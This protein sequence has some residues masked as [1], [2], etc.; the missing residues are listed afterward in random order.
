VTQAT[1]ASGPFVKP[2]GS[3]LIFLRRKEEGRTQREVEENAGLPLL[4]LYL[5]EKG[6][7]ISIDHLEKLAAYYG[8]PAAELIEPESLSETLSMIDNSCRVLEHRPNLKREGIE[9]WPL[10]K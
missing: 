9:K 6:K 1:K 5:Y 7:A 4:R 8:I 3:F 10:E 2:K